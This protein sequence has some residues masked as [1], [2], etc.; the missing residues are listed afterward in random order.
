VD[1]DLTMTILANNLYRLI[2]A[3]L[4]GYSHNSAETIYDKFI[5]NSAYVSIDN[6]SVS[7]ELKKKRNLPALLTAMQQFS[8][9]KIP[10]YD[11]RKI[12]FSGAT[13]S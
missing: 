1:F 2:A 7:V 11:E 5:A 8:N 3:D 6:N 12:T 13:H 4:E 9:L 10:L